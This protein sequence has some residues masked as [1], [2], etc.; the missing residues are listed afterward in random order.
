MLMAHHMV[1]G[2]DRQRMHRLRSDRLTYFI[3]RENCLKNE[4]NI[5]AGLPI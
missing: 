3:E 2:F 4:E 1:V 5:I